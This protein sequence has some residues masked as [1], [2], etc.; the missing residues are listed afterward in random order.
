MK[1]EQIAVIGLSCLFPDA[2]NPEQFWQ[3]LVQGK[4]STSDA[5]ID[6]F[7]VD[8]KIFRGE[9][10][11]NPD[12][13]YSLKG[14]FIR[15]FRFDASGYAIAPKT[16]AGLDPIAQA[17]L[18]VARQALQNSGYWE[19]AWGESLQTNTP[20]ALRDKCGVILGNLSLPLHHS[21]RLFGPMYQAGI[22]PAVQELLQDPEFRF[23]PL[24]G[25]Q[26]P[27]DLL[28]ARMSSLPSQIVAEALSLSNLH[29]AL[30]AACSS[31]LYA[32]ELARH[33]LLSGEADLMLAGA[34]S[35][36]D[37]LFV[38]MLFSGLQA[39]PDNGVSCPFDERSRGLTPADGVG[40]LVLKR[41]SDAVR[42]G[43]TIHAIVSGVGLSNDGRG[44]HLL[45][46]NQKGQVIAFE[47]AYEA[48][49]LSPKDVDYVECHATGTLLGDS[50]EL[51][52]IDEFFHSAGAKPLVGAVKANT[53][54]LLTAAGMVSLLKVIL[55]MEHGLIPPTINLQ[56]PQT[57][58]HG[59]VSRDRIV[60]EPTPWPV[61]GKPKRT[62]I[63]AFGFG[64]TNAHLILE[65]APQAGA[66][67]ASATPFTP[68]ET[69]IPLAIVGM[70]ACFGDADGLDA[71]DRAFYDGTQQ[72]KPLP[73]QRWQGL[74]HCTD[75]LKAYGFEAAPEGA[76]IDQ[77]DIDPIRYK[78]PPNEVNKLQPQQLLMLKVADR[79]LQDAQIKPGDNVAVLIAMETELSIHQLQQRWNF[80]WQVEAGLVETG[81]KLPADKLA[82]LTQILKDSL[83]PPAQTSEY[84]GY[85]GNI[86]PSRISALWDFKAPSFTLSAGE[87]SALKALEVAQNLLAYGH[88][89]AV[90]VGAVDLAGGFEQVLLRNQVAR[91]NTGETDSGKTVS[92][93]ASKPTLSF[94]QQAQ[95]AMV[96][97]GAG[98]VVLKRLEAARVEGDR[99]YAVVDALSFANLPRSSQTA[100]RTAARPDSVGA[101]S[102]CVAHVCAT[103]YAQ[104]GISTAEIGY[105]EV[106]GSGVPRADSAEMI[107]LTQAYRLSEVPASTAPLA[108][109]LTCALGSATANIGHTG[110]AAA[111][112]SLI[113][114]ALCLYHRYIPAVPNWSAPQQPK[115]DSGRSDSGRSDSGRSDSNIW[116]NTPFYVASDSRAWLLGAGST[117][118]RAALSHISL[119][120]IASHLVLSEALAQP[121]RSRTYLEQRP[122]HLFPIAGRDRADLEANLAAF[123]QALSTS[124]SLA[125]LARTCFKTYR[126]QAHLPYVLGL[127]GGQK[128]KLTRDLSKASAAI[129]KAFETGQDWQAPSGSF[130]TANPQGHPQGVNG[131]VAFVYPG[132]F[133]CYMGQVRDRF[134]LF[135]EI[136]NLP[137]LEQLREPLG[138]IDRMFYPRSLT[139]LSKRDLEALDLQLM[140]D[141]IMMFESEIGCSGITTAVLED[142]FKIQ[143]HMAFGYSLGETSMMLAQRV[144]EDKSMGQVSAQVLQ[145]P[146]FHER[147]AGAKNAVRDYWGMPRWPKITAKICGA[148]LWWWRRLRRSGRPSSPSI[149]FI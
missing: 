82:A 83:H 60:T 109:Q 95:G 125:Q 122:F 81:G 147:L 57:S 6:E 47:R 110:V 79:A 94:D 134:R 135:P 137:L 119:E 75:L 106:C 4:D 97:E 66:A 51:S 41:Y 68:H 149:A 16:L 116:N 40:M 73:Q 86:M 98:A 12:Q 144:F 132:A 30:D 146:L 72:F 34:A 7:G 29:F 59:V 101:A 93:K 45:S 22:A 65:E 28:N 112:A 56:Q 64:G 32:V 99:I 67:D 20:S 96:G 131:K 136:F 2:E 76:Y 80:D 123:E 35:Y 87:D 130:F 126:Q 10:K 88:A 140:A 61:T 21:N 141:P 77:V 58:P 46:P 5:T 13:T 85:I 124:D 55:G 100:G 27:V 104:L 121:V 48:A 71:I 26:Q 54:H 9:G 18:Y 38:R 14:G 102:D 115:A 138:R 23:A 117:Q 120:G 43:D 127:V 3:N 1:T 62:A 69:K 148:I 139:G 111:I 128:D 145:S 143:P 49:G 53:G 17:S 37:S 52:S 15:D 31:S 24:P 19:T 8:P 50:T 33:Y 74:E 113:K 84:V 63:N 142:C 42:D 118:R 89:D 108:S 78:I 92:G 44:K 114:T 36:S 11:E 91:I 107:G 25:T 103:A 129:A 39:Y 105:L 90:L 70:D 133:G